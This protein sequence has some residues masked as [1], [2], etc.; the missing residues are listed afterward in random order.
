M[1]S[2]D[3]PTAAQDKVPDRTGAGNIKPPDISE[4]LFADGFDRTMGGATDKPR[5]PAQLDLSDPFKSSGAPGDNAVA[6]LPGVAAPGDANPPRAASDAAAV[7][8]QPG[9]DAAA[10]P[11]AAADRSDTAIASQNLVNSGVLGNLQLV[12]NGAPVAGGPSPDAKA[13][14]NL[15]G[16]AVGDGTEEGQGGK[17]LSQD[18]IVAPPAGG[19]DP[20]GEVIT[21][22]D[23]ETKQSLEGIPQDENGKRFPEPSALAPF[24]VSG[25]SNATFLQDGKLEIDAISQAD[26]TLTKFNLGKDGLV[27][28]RSILNAATLDGATVQFDSA[29]NPTSRILVENGKL[30]ATSLALDPDDHVTSKIDKDGLQITSKNAAG[31]TELSLNDNFQ[32][33]QT[34]VTKPATDGGSQQLQT[35]FN[36]EGRAFSKITANFDAQGGFLSSEQLSVAKNGDETQEFTNQDGSFTRSTLDAAH[37]ER[38]RVVSLKDGTVLSQLESD[39]V[40]VDAVTNGKTGDWFRRLQTEANQQSGSVRWQIGGPNWEQPLVTE[41]PI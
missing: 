10:R 31:T 41:H 30:T 35:D 37:D 36:E 29:G 9:V 33:E 1:A 8:N 26:N 14:A 16:T 23:L 25:D 20:K 39:D 7:A 4:N 3:S 19:V 40:K 15:P 18:G 28:S 27:E 32:V 22:D 6:R 38:T 13:G 12:D 24:E 5:E 2:I 21:R 34:I 11:T 17:P